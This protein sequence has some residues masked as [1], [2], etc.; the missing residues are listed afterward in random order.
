MLPPLLLVR[1]ARGLAVTG[2]LALFLMIEIGARELF[3][4]LLVLQLMLLWVE[5]P[6]LARGLPV[7]VGV[8]V[9]LLATIAGLL[10]ACEFT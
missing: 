1:R 5:R 4:G 2:L 3:F 10:P 9:V 8:Y 6:W 7:L